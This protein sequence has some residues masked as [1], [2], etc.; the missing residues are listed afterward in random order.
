[1]AISIHP[2]KISSLQGSKFQASLAGAHLVEELISMN[3]DRAYYRM[4]R[5]RIIRKKSCFLRQYG[6]DEM[7][8][9]WSRGIS[10]RLSKG[11][12][13]CSCWLCRKKTKDEPTHSDRKK[14][15]FALQ[16]LESVHTIVK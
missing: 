8:H 13:H 3:R 4:Q 2:D 10:G 7:L 14:Y 1:M 5:T 9:G 12:I 11:K 6:G 15:A 16:Q